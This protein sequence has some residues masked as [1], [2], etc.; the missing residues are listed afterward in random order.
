MKL[1]NLGDH[2]SVK[3]NLINPIYLSYNICHII[4]RHYNNLLSIKLTGLIEFITNSY[5]RKRLIF[6]TEIVNIHL[7]II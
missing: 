1:I 3:H 5:T 6:K 7:F 2:M 4:Y